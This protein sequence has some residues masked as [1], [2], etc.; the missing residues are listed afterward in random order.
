MFKSD[1]IDQLVKRHAQNATRPIIDASI[2]QIAEAIAKET[3]KKEPSTSVIWA[4]LNRIGA[5][6]KGKRWAWRHNPPKGAE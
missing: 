2:R 4:S 3:G 5:V 6:S 1:E